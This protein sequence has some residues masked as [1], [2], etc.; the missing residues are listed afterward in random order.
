MTPGSWFAGSL[1][2]P[3]LA[4]LSFST[5]WAFG[6]GPSHFERVPV[7]RMGSTCRTQAPLEVVSLPFR[8]GFVEALEVDRPLRQ[9]VA[10]HDGR[11][12]DG[13]GCPFLRW[14]FQQKKKEEAT[15]NEVDGSDDDG[16]AQHEA[17]EAAA[18]GSAGLR[19]HRSPNQPAGK[20]DAVRDSRQAGRAPKVLAG[21]E[22]QCAVDVAE[23]VNVTK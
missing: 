9:L 3:T 17:Q 20:P 10:H 2:E 12:P 11:A 8:R 18:A 16:L 4:A 14:L 13:G 19:C 15:S 22:V 5:R 21:F 1:G 23:W 6:E 7:K